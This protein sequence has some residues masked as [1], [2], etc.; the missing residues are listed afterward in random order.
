MQQYQ[1]SLVKA[2]GHGEA[3]GAEEE[4]RQRNVDIG[5]IK[6]ESN[7]GQGFAQ[8]QREYLMDESDREFQ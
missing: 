5:P 6:Q 7:V 3:G 2:R 8:M 4:R 1:E